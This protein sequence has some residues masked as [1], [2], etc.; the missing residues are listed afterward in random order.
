MRLKNRKTIAV[1]MGDPAGIGPEVLVKALRN[2]GIRKRGPFCII[3]D[4]TIL[5]RYASSLPGNCDLRDLKLLSEN[6]VRPGQ[7]TPASAQASLSYLLAAVDLLKRKGAHA[8]VTAPVHKE[9]ICTSG[10]HFEGHT[11]FLARAF[12][13]KHV[14]MMFVARHLRVVLLTRHVPL[15]RVSRMISAGALLGTVQRARQSLRAQFGI[16]NPRIAVC[17]LNP[18]AGEGGNI[19][20]EEIRILI[21]AITAAKKRGIPIEGPFAA[22]TLFTPHNSK[23]YDLIIA[24]YHDQGLVAV[25]A[26]FF[27]DLVNFTAGLPFIRTSPAHGTAFNIAGKAVAHAGSMTAALRLADELTNG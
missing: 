25:K 24:M 23:N 12:H 18:H 16:P 21:P 15:K 26:L 17:G 5:N 8:L 1:T 11:E 14:E 20:D 2:P 6:A 7:G 19:G 27:H 3:G 22:D 10:C 13:R 9:N 4:K